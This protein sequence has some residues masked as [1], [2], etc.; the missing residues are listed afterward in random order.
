M[1]RDDIPEWCYAGDFGREG[2]RKCKHVG[3]WYSIVQCTTCG[4][5][6]GYMCKQPSGTFHFARLLRAKVVAEM[7]ARRDPRLR[8]EMFTIGYGFWQLRSKLRDYKRKR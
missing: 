8:E 2:F 6:A 3:V 4:A 1:R 5:P 7:R